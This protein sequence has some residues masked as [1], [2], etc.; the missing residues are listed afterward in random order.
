[1]WKMYLL[2][3]YTSLKTTQDS[4]TRKD[5]KNM[6]SI[7][8]IILKVKYKNVVAIAWTPSWKEN[9]RYSA[10]VKDGNK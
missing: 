4:Y 2:L 8:N 9:L 10:G 7:D 1:M 6:A 3:H 5:I